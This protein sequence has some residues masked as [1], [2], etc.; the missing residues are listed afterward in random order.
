LIRGTSMEQ[1]KPAAE[2]LLRNAA[3]HGYG[4]AQNDLGFAILSGQT[5]TSDLVEA[6][7]W[8]QLAASGLTSSNILQRAKV[9]LATALSRL[10]ADQQIE[11]E[12]RVKAFQPLAAADLDPMC[13]DWE[14]NPLYVQE[15]GRF[16][17]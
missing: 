10:T 16:G 2:K 12:Q 15:D 13:R 8:C 6:A 17:H 4:Q 1:D 7:M 11:V 9:N 3:A 5:S 14:N